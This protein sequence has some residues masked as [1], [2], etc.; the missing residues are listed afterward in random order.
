MVEARALCKVNINGVEGYRL[1]DSSGKVMDVPSKSIINAMANNKIIVNNLTI[2]DNDNLLI[3]VDNENIND[4]NVLE[5]MHKLISLIDKYRNEYYNEDREEVDN[6]EYDRLKDELDELERKAG[7]V[8][9]NS[10]SLK[11]GCEVTSK[12][13]KYTFK[14]PM[15]SLSKTKEVSGLQQFLSD[16]DGILSWKM[17]GLTVV[18]A[19]NN[20]ELVS[21]ITRG[22]GEIGEVIT[23]NAKHFRNLP[24]RIPYKGKLVLRGEAVMT[25]SDFER[26]NKG[27]VTSGDELKKN[28]RNL[29]S[30][31]V[32]SVDSSVTKNR[33]VYWYAFELVS[34][35]CE[36]PNDIDKQFKWLNNNGFD[37][38]QFMVVNS[39]NVVQAVMQFESIVES[40][41]LDIP[42]DGL[43]LTYRDKK[44]GESLGV[45]AKSP[46][47]SIAFKWED[48]AVETKVIDIEWSPSRNGLITPVAIFEPVDIE[49]STV[50]RASLHNVSIFAE[51]QLGYG[52]RIKV[53][54]ANM[55]IPQVL[56]NLDRTATCQIPGQCPCCGEPT[57]L[58]QDPKSG[59]YTLWCENSEC[60]AKGTRSFEHFV[61][62]DAMN[63]D[64]VST[65]TLNTLIECRIISDYASIYHINEHADEII[66]LEGFGYTSFMNIV[67]AVEKS[68]NVKPANLIYALGIPNIGLTTAKLICKHFGND[69]VKTVTA[70]YNDLINIDG[71]GDTIADS[72]TAYF[73][74]KNNA[75]AFVRLTKE[76][77]IIQ[78]AVSNNTEMNGITICVTG[79][80]HIF[81]NRRAIKDIVENL[82]GKLTG[83]VSKSTSYL[84][85][86]D[87]TSGSRKNKAAQEYG[88]PI[89]TEQQ[90]IEKFN[91]QKYV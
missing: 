51:K 24:L 66:N 61:A 79:D 17:D 14:K 18:V 4:S 3:V 65:S 86:N 28:P 55:I 76:L 11:V 12:L 27:L 33:G 19:Y 84:V 67:N 60:A 26:I 25:Y 73:A 64:G 7:F 87:T 77:N 34:A 49:G 2:D 80:V 36:I 39:S 13:P 75:E 85:T 29:C 89:L 10:P 30:G 53:Y 68:R 46:R 5:K 90:F 42:T 52:D 72:F 69:L 15:L 58:H 16:K 35:D 71:I 88:I 23:Q 57:V 20:G 78:E 74:D 62:R 82:G 48:E 9:S 63:I 8:L 32:R 45:R 50:S 47:H 6:K 21:A 41:K 54:K 83:S 1:Q 22:N 44:Y 37:T 70:S 38:V 81:K 59:V 40:K 91:L 56:D 43:V 31:T